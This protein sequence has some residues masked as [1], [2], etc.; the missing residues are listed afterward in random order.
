MFSAQP[1]YLGVGTV[2][3]AE[4]IRLSAE[5]QLQGAIGLHSLP[6]AER[7]Y[8][9][10]CRMT[11]VAQDPDYFDLAYFEFTPAAAIDWLA[12]IGECL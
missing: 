4:A 12:S 3:I 1:R 10:R 8:A 11:R 9:E 6:Q 5:M 2:L 7:F